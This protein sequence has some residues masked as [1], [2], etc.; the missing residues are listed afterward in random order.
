MK[1]RQRLV[2]Q[3]CF[4][5]G[6]AQAGRPA[7]LPPAEPPY[8]AP[9]GPQPLD[10]PGPGGHG[11]K[12]SRRRLV[13]PFLLGALG[14]YALYRQQERQTPATMAGP[15]PTME[16]TRGEMTSKLRVGG[17]IS[18]SR[19][20]AVVAPRLQGRPGGGGRFRLT[21]LAMAKPGSMVEKGEIVA[22]FDRQTQQQTIDDRHAEVVQ[23]QAQI[24]KNAAELAIAMETTQ[25]QLRS[26]RAEWDKA[27]LD[28]RTGEVRSRIEAEIL[29]LNVEETEA[30]YRQLQKEV[31]LLETAHAAKRRAL[32]IARDQKK[33]DETRARI[34][35]DKMVLRAGISGMVVMQTIFRGGGQFS[36]V[37]E[38]D[39]VNSG[40]FF[41]QIVDTSSMILNGQLNQV[42]SQLVRAGRQAEIRLDAYPDKVWPGRVTA[43]GA[44]AGAG[45][46][47]MRLPRAMTRAE[48]VRS[49]PVTFAIDARAPE[50][51]PDLSGSADILLEQHSDVITVPREAVHWD[52]SGEEIVFV[53]KPGGPDFEARRI[54]TGAQDNVTT[55]VTAGL[56]PGEEIAL[57]RPPLKL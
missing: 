36:Q 55:V 31:K 27:M 16:V 23:A 42:D 53:R 17:T 35:T 52:E 32:E 19:S 28:L 34:N 54:E 25:Q 14:G 47:G 1:P 38:G 41:M 44:I 7:P 20:S 29:K 40:A 15:V 5:A 24:D 4:A 11:P 50:I 3:L 18:A 22:E 57:R 46:G 8:P 21:L 49:V 6:E 13:I 56:D 10:D 37:Q 45:G 9:A 43:V 51:I 26:A 12:I 48:Y 2:P 39:E 30:A 33:I